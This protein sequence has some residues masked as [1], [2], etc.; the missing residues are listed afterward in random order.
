MEPLVPAAATTAASRASMK[1]E[2]V[3]FETPFYISGSHEH[4]AAVHLLQWRAIR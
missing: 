4:L 3:L 2:I 1:G